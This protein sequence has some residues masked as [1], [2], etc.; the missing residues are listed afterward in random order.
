[1]PFP[2]LAALPWIIGGVSS[3]ASNIIASRSSKKQTDATNA[4]NMELA[5][6]QADVNQ[7]AID[8]QNLYNSPEQQMGRFAQ[9]GL[10]PNLIYGSGSGSAGNQ[11]GIAQY[12]APR[13][14]MHYTPFQLPEMLSQYQE[15]QMR[16]AQIDN[17]NAS[18]EEKRTNVA[19]A[20]LSRLLTQVN[21]S[22][23]QFDLDQLK[24]LAPYNR[25]IVEQRSNLS[26]TNWNLAL[27][28]LKQQQGMNPLLMAE[29]VNKIDMQRSEA[30]KKE[31]DAL[32]AQ[33]K[34]QMFKDYKMTPSDNVVLRMLVNAIMQSG[35]DLQSY[36]PK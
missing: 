14:D 27:E 33:L 11:S 12:N 7:K 9:A 21:T 36:I 1:M 16:K 2:L 10:N 25:N 17:V 6:Y 24:Q 32:Y 4:A 30:Q 13:V 19:N 8:R 3:L 35:V 15:F 18:T 5:K 31:A 26:N 22:R 20:V 34:A 28:K 29:K 23:K